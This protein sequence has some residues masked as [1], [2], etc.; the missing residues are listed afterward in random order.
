VLAKDYFKVL[1]EEIG[2]IEAVMTV[3]EEG[4]ARGSTVCAAGAIRE[5]RRWMVRYSL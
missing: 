5:C 3:V 4:R 2:D 1:V